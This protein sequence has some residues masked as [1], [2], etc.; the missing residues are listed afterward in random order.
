MR[1]QKFQHNWYGKRGIS[2]YGFYV[3]AQ[4]AVGERRIEV[5]DLWCPDTEQDA[6]LTQCAL[7]VE[8]ASMEK[9]FPIFHIYFLVSTS[10]SLSSNCVHYTVCKDFYCRSHC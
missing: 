2:L 10:E 1:S 7:D 3:I 9:V 6:C 4:V 5:L 8:F